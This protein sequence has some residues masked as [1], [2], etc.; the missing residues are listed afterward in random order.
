MGLMNKRTR[1]D[2]VRSVLSSAQ[3]LTAELLSER[4]TLNARC[5]RLES[6]CKKAELD[7][8]RLCEQVELNAKLHADFSEAVNDVVQE[9][10]KELQRLSDRIDRQE[11]EI[12]SLRAMSG[13]RVLN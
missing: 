12:Q 11:A 6:R 1:T 4:D 7:A 13:H 3:K 8:E 5:E 10:R 9:M 2:D